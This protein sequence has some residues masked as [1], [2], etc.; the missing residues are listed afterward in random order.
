MADDLVRL[1]RL[2]QPAVDHWAAGRVSDCVYLYIS[3]GDER[4]GFLL[5]HFH[6]RLIPFI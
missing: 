2:Q 5:K 3:R 1:D 4:R 6:H